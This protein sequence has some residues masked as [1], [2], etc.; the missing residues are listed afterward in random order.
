MAQ[1]DPTPALFYQ[2]ALAVLE[3]HAIHP[4]MRLE[5]I[6]KLVV[7][8]SSVGDEFAVACQGNP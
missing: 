4:R 5:S 7:F 2:Y 3:D 6:I 1:D 8:W